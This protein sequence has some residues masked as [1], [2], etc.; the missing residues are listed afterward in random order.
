MST[1]PTPSE[2]RDQILTDIESGLGQSVPLLSKS[3]FRIIATAVGGVLSLL[4]RYGAWVREQIFTQTM[5]SDSLILR[6]AEYGMRRTPATKWTGTIE[7]TGTDDTVV[8]LGTLFQY[9]GIVYRTTAAVTISGT[10]TASAE[11]L[12][13]GDEVDRI[14]GDIMEIVT[15]QTGV[16]KEATVTAVSQSGEDA[17]GDTSFRSRIMA[18]QS[19]A[20]QGGAAAD[21]VAWARE[22]SGVVKAFAF[23]TGSGEVTVYPLVG[24]DADDRLPDSS[25]LTEVQTYVGSTERCP[26]TASVVAAALSEVT[27]NITVTTLNPDTTALRTSIES[28]LGAYFLGRYPKQYTDEVNPTNVISVAEL[29]K[30]AFDAGT[31][32]V[33]MTVDIDGGYSGITGYTLQYDELALLGTITWPS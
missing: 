17:E 7:I 27:F 10:T 19:R 33:S 16:D 5:N 3:V 2:L 11:S 15:P 13:T 21:F 26:L 12:E 22:V 8:A 30:V 18:R 24:Y 31:S 32:F 1:T 28:A 14:E 23:N 25:K 4:Y 6:A 9:D 20:P 29:H